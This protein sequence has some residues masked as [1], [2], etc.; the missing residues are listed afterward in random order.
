MTQEA[1]TATTA[2]TTVHFEVDEDNF[3]IQ[4]PDGNGHLFLFGIM[5][6]LMKIVLR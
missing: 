3:D 5:F 2:E 6:Y 1:N 4:L